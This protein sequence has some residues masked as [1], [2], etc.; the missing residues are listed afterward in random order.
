MLSF[1]PVQGDIAAANLASPTENTPFGYN[2]K[3]VEV[4]GNWYFAKKSSLKAGYEGEIMDRS[5]RDVEHSTENG[6]V[7]AVDSSPAQEPFLPR[8]VPLFVAQSRALRGRRGD[9]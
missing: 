5:N 7:A 2:K 6:L 9:E 3:N 4:T 8:V 1:T